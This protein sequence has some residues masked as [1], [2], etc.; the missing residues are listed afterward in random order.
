MVNS[1]HVVGGGLADLIFN[2]QRYF[3]VYGAIAYFVFTII[4]C[5]D[6]TCCVIGNNKYIRD[7]WGGELGTIYS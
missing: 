2:F 6:I 1:A 3:I 4:R 5:F 7:E